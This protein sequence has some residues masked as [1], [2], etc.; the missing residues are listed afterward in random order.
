[1]KVNFI[2]RDQAVTK[3]QWQSVYVPCRKDIFLW[4]VGVVSQPV[5]VSECR[6]RRLGDSRLAGGPELWLHS[7]SLRWLSA[8]KILK[9]LLC[10]VILAGRIL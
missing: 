4:N 6:K 9:P 10:V 3:L 5:M 2:A 7:V 1:M 8:L